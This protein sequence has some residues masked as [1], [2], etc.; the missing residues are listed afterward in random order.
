MV[1][2]NEHNAGDLLRAGLDPESPHPP[3]VSIAAAIHDGRRRRASRRLAVAGGVAVAIAV[4]V[5]VPAALAATRNDSA[6]AGPDPTPPATPHPVVT[7]TGTPGPTRSVPP[8]GGTPGASYAAPPFATAPAACDVHEL[9]APAGGGPTVVSAGSPDGSV[10]YGLRHRTDGTDEV[11]RWQAGQ[12]SLPTLPGEDPLVVAVNNGGDAVGN[13]TIAGRP[14][15]WR[16][17][18]GKATLLPGEE[19]A[20]AKAVN[21][22]GDVAGNR[23][24]NDASGRPIAWRGGNPPV[25][26]PLP[27]GATGG[28][29]LAIDFWGTVFGSVA[30]GTAE[31]PYS[32]DVNG[33]GAPLPLPPGSTT[34][35][36]TSAREGWASGFADQSTAHPKPV[37]WSTLGGIVV[38]L[39]GIE[40][41]AGEVNANGF[42]L[43]R[44][45]DGRAVLLADDQ[46]IVLPAILD[47]TAAR[48]NTPVTLSDDG[49]TIVGQA[50]RPDGSFQAV[51]WTCH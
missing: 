25:E 18:D 6:P 44:A 21:I 15:A 23:G 48:P 49:R 40:S 22:K 30:Y 36:V 47:P 20:F 17:H 31:V 16:L 32:W 34:A 37:R 43:G 51:V 26:L 41:P 14:A 1:D 24:S 8:P 28:R 39:D 35:V 2:L 7:D 19:R 29:A 12:P 5:A 42:V 38:V 10:H 3:R 9:A 4:A 27:S 11:V 50:T 46:R 33:T 13:S 45:T